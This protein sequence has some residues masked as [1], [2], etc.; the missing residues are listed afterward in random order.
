M[1]VFL[2][3]RVYPLSEESGVVVRS[4]NKARD[5]SA[6]RRSAVTSRW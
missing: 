6:E 4:R 1:P 3:E 5:R 2:A